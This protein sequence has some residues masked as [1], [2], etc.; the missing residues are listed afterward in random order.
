MN[1]LT[2]SKLPDILFKFPTVSKLSK[3]FPTTQT[4]CHSDIFHYLSTF[5]TSVVSGISSIMYRI[6]TES[7]LPI[8]TTQDSVANYH[9]YLHGSCVKSSFLGHLSDH[10]D[11]QSGYLDMLSFYLN[12]VRLFKQSSDC[13]SFKYLIM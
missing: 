11:H 2:I 13:L 6:C 4:L 5:S 12:H 10:S 9:L 3:F 1:F 7:L 8:S